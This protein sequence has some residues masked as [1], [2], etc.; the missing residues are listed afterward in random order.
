MELRGNSPDYQGSNYPFTLIYGADLSQCGQ[1]IGRRIYPNQIISSEVL[2][3]C[4]QGNPI[5][6]VVFGQAIT[7]FDQLEIVA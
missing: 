3:H 6:R 1:D 7:N 2:G 5:I 4:Y